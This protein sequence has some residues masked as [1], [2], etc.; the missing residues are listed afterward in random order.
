M[1]VANDLSTCETNTP[2]QTTSWCRSNRTA[3]NTLSV[4]VR[5]S[6]PKSDICDLPSAT[7]LYFEVQL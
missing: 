1:V 6:G 5:F 7:V 2:L 4:I 3:F